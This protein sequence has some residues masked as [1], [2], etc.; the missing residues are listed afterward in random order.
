MNRRI[1]S[2]PLFLVVIIPFLSIEVLP[3]SSSF[4]CFHVL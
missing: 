1:N 2:F 4:F 3:L